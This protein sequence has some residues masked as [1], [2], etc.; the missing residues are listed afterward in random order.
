MQLNKMHS[1]RLR[2]HFND[3]AP[4]IGSGKR[5]VLVDVGRKIVRVRDMHGNRAKFTKDEWERII[6]NNAMGLGE[7]KRHRR[8][9][10]KAQ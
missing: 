6:R 10:W 4:R 1:E 2:V 9:W 5:I 7:V 3:E 8:P